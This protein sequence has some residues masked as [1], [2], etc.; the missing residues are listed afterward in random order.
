MNMNKAISGLACGMLLLVSVNS[1]AN[2]EE[3]KKVRVGYIGLTCEASIFAAVENGFF[4]EEGLDI[5][6]V[7]CDWK[8]Y[9]DSL[10]LGSYDFTQHLVMYFL[11]PIEQGLDVKF[12]AGVHTGCLRVQVPVNSPVKTVAEL[13]GKRIAVPGMGTPPFIF[14]TRALSNAGL[15]PAKDIEWKVY[16]PAEQGLAIDKGEV[17]AVANAEPIGSMLLGSGKV[18]NLADQAK[19]TPYKDEYCCEVVANGKWLAKNPKTAAAATRALLKGAKWVNTNP[20]AAAKMA[21]EKKYL[22]ANPELNATAISHLNYLPSVSRA[23]SSVR[24]AAIEMKKA[25]MLAP[26][27]NPEELAKRAFMHLEGVTDEWIEKLEVQ[28]VAGGDVIPSY[29]ATNVS[30]SAPG[31]D[32]GDCCAMPVS[33]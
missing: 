25:A 15:D 26:T 21:V 6:L 11:K 8:T 32:R 24:T 9:K 28:K 23:E 19:D 20:P 16:P 5:E 29:A 30:G 1:Q 12:L 33:N 18:R 22:A 4:K 17:D 14:A 27:T 31:S 3:S 2:A 13:R 7:K 10:A